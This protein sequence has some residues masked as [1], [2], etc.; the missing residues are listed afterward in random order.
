[1]RRDDTTEAS[2]KEVY[3]EGR[4]WINLAL[5]TVLVSALLKYLVLL[6]M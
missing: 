1:M 3:Y 4:K 5:D 6:A 2:L